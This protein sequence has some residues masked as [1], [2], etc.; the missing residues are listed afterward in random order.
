MKKNDE[1]LSLDQVRIMLHISKRKAAWML[2]NQIIPCE[3]NEKSTH[4]YAVRREDVD[5]FLCLPAAE[6]RAKFP[7]GQFNASGAYRFAHP[8]LHLQLT[9]TERAEF[10]RCLED[11]YADYPDALTVST[12]CEMT[13]YSRTTVNNWIALGYVVSANLIDGPRIP[14]RSLIQFLA[15]T[16]AFDIRIKSEAHI[17]LLNIRE[18]CVRG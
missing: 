6:Q 13:G 3:I 7:V 11:F 15:S 14:K 12:V 16:K 4:K 5:A 8:E 2:Q 18:R 17:N 9:D 10:V 1:I